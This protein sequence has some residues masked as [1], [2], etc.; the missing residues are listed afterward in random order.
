[1]EIYFVNYGNGDWKARVDKLCIETEGYCDRLNDVHVVENTEIDEEFEKW[2]DEAWKR[3]QEALKNKE[4]IEFE[5]IERPLGRCYGNSYWWGVTFEHLDGDLWEATTYRGSN[6]WAV[7]QDIGMTGAKTDS[8]IYVNIDDIENFFE[9]LFHN[10]KRFYEELDV[11]EWVNEM[12]GKADHSLYAPDWEAINEFMNLLHEYDAMNESAMA[13][14]EIWDEEEFK[15]E[16]VNV[17]YEIGEEDRKKFI[18]FLEKLR[19]EYDLID[20]EEQ[21]NTI[22]KA[23]EKAKDL[24]DIVDAFERVFAY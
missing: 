7:W 13:I 17:L 10:P 4:N 9:D 16:L 20:D 12:R 2:S 15:Q 24:G 18:N 23:I 8:T 11:W 5:L 19:D 3:F 6:T 14:V 21:F 1:M 22:K